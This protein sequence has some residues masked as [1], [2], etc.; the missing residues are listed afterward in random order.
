M[1]T[2]IEIYLN[3]LSE[4]ILEL[5]INLKNISYIPHLTRFKNL[6]KLSCNYN[7]LTSLPTL[8]KNIEVLYCFN[9]Q[10]TSLSTL[11]ENLEELYCFNNQLTSLPIL[12]E[13]LQEFYC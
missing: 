13:N 5:N 1:T 6:E 3:S 8:P 10:L 9:N 2:Q 7:Q 11:P 12:P 4:D